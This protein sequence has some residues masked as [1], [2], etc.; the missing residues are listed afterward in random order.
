MIYKDLEEIRLFHDGLVPDGEHAPE[1][2][3]EGFLINCPYMS[4]VV[5]PSEITYKKKSY[6]L[7]KIKS[8][9]FSSTAH[10]TFVN[11]VK[12]KNRE[13]N[14]AQF[15]AY[16]DDASKLVMEVSER[17][18]LGNMFG[19]CDRET[20]IKDLFAIYVRLLDATRH[21]RLS[22]YNASMETKGYL[23]YLYGTGD[24]Y[25]IR[26]YPD[27][28]NTGREYSTL[29]YTFSLINDVIFVRRT[30]KAGLLGK[31]ASLL[32]D[33]HVKLTADLDIIKEVIQHHCSDL[34]SASLVKKDWVDKFRIRHLY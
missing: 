2:D 10:Q 5:T 13:Y 23:D 14:S 21:I 27:K 33:P 22:K 19:P 24:L 17:G 8:L 4:L 16:F 12:I 30:E 29:Q 28:I 25:S 18:V 9:V 15:F 26:L 32:N 11:G 34:L 7:A 6:S 20:E 3:I 31:L 1:F